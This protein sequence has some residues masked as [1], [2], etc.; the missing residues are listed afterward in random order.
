[1]PDASLTLG[2]VAAATGLEA[3]DHADLVINGVCALQP[4]QPGCIAFAQGK[5]LAEAVSGSDAAAVILTPELAAQVQAL[6]VVG[7]PVLLLAAKP[8]L[9]FVQVAGL[10]AADDRPDLGIHPTASVHPSAS[11]GKD[12]RIG[13]NCSI[14]ANASIGDGSSLGAGCVVGRDAKIGPNAD[15]ASNVTIAD[16]VQIGARALILPGAV[17]GS[18]GFGNAHDGQ[19]WHAV[20]QIGTVIV[21]DD[22]EIGA[23]TAIDRGALGDTVI[24]DNVR[25]DNLCQIAH[26]VHI[27]KRTAIASGVGI[28]GSARIGQDCMLGGQVGV[29]GHISICDGAVINGGS[30]VLQSVEAPG[31]YASGVPLMPAMAWRRFMAL[32]NRLE[33]RLKALERS[34]R[35]KGSST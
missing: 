4:G 3:S 21:G 2:E 5:K 27:G 19:R 22:V 15:I 25:I 9:A 6:A 31:Q 1:M 26:N 14:A 12:L 29:N 23:N 28:A 35:Q 13:P 33:G 7:M 10:F 11:L 24:E 18:R 32:V 20:P 30:K 16:R 34:S 8:Q 17:I